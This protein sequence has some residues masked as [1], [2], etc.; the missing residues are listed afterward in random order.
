M[1]AAVLKA[2]GGEECAKLFPRVMLL[3][4]AV[5]AAA[6]VADFGVLRQEDAGIA[7]RVVDEIE[8]GQ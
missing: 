7:L 2:Y 1:R 5:D 4:V 8:A 3:Q 6:R